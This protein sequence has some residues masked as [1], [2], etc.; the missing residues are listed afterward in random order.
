MNQG[1]KVCYVLGISQHWND[2]SKQLHFSTHNERK[3]NNEMGDSPLLAI[4]LLSTLQ[5]QCI[6]IDQGGKSCKGLLEQLLAKTFE[7]KFCAFL[8]YLLPLPWLQGYQAS[9]C[10]RSPMQQIQWCGRCPQ[11]WYSIQFVQSS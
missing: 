9:G 2:S 6:F 1:F 5:Y 11:L 8:L 3:N 7:A 10:F 4:M